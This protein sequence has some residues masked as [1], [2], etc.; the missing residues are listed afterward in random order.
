VADQ[1]AARRYPG[2]DAFACDDGYVNTAPVGSF[3]ANAFGLSDMLGN[4][5][6]WTQDCWHEDYSGAPT[7]GS[8][9]ADG[10]CNQRELRGGSWFSSPSYVTASY[11]NHFAADYRASSVGF[12][13][14]RDINP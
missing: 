12:R 4:V 13:L 14:V 2:W 8:A 3:S 9:R 7:D 1:S 11:R 5:F 6:E 10:D